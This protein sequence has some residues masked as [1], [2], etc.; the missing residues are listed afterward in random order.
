MTAFAMVFSAFVVHRA[1]QAFC[2]P[3]A[4]EELRLL[5]RFTGLCGIAAFA[6]SGLLFTP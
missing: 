5:A 1:Q 2:D 3:F 4:P 6:L